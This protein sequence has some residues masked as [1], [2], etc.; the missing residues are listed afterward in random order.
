MASEASKRHKT[1]LQL[2]Y[3][4]EAEFNL[5]GKSLSNDIAHAILSW[6]DFLDLGAVALGSKRQAWLVSN[7]F[8]RSLSLITF[9][10]LLSRRQTASSDDGATPAATPP[11]RQQYGCITRLLEGSARRLHTIRFANSQA[12]ML[13]QYESAAA[14]EFLT[15]L[16][17][18]NA[19]TFR[20]LV[21]PTDMGGHIH[22]PLTV[23]TEL[24]QCPVLNYLHLHTSR[25]VDDPQD[26][27]DKEFQALERSLLQEKIGNLD[28]LVLMD[29]ADDA[30]A[31][32][33]LAPLISRGGHN[34]ARL[35]WRDVVSVAE[36]V[37]LVTTPK[38]KTH[39]EFNSIRYVVFMVCLCV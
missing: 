19:N 18:E 12:W 24:R 36:F 5:A 28:S 32:P 1:G 7:Y 39:L 37:Q 4:N 20:G 10:L 9:P 27:D 35:I 2:P 23:M 34:L 29:S 14:Q 26:E 25:W 31:A 17:H 30:D 8:Q 22:V 6:L 33:M 11:L 3:C 13:F 21:L 15:K 38:P 16:V